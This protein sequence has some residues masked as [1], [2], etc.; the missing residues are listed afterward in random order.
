[1]KEIIRDGCTAYTASKNGMADWMDT[2]DYEYLNTFGAN[3]VSQ[4]QTINIVSCVI[5]D[6]TFYQKSEIS[7]AIHYIGYI[8]RVHTVYCAAHIGADPAKCP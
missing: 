2:P 5:C 8:L 4:M 1:M 3:K 7:V 6:E